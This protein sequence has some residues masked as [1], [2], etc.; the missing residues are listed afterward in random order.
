METW[1]SAAFAVIVT[2]APRGAAAARVWVGG[3]GA[4]GGAGGAG[5][6]VDGLSDGVG[7]AGAAAVGEGCGVGLA[8]TGAGC[9]GGC[10][11]GAGLVHIAEAPEAPG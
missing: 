4:T 10:C 9:G 8:V 2:G 1:P 11:A 3:G 5:W 7:D 6:D